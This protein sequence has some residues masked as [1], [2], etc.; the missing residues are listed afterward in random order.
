MDND[1]IKGKVDEVA[2]KVK[3][4][5]G[6]MT[7]DRSTQAEGIG[8]QIKGKVENAFGKVKDEGRAAIEEN[9][10]KKQIEEEERV[11]NRRDDVA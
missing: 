8:Q 2:G 10:E 7:G 9:R 11:E 6:E 5:V 3:S 1:R 4:K